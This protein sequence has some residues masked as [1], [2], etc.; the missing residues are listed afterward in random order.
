MIIENPYSQTNPEN[1]SEP[2]DNSINVYKSSVNPQGGKN[3]L[4]LIISVVIILIAAI[5]LVLYFTGSL[6]HLISYS[7]ASKT[8]FPSYVLSPKYF[9][10]TLELFVL[11]LEPAI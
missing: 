10:F 9:I 4:G 8:L 5:L 11:T 1:P 7:T 6:S 2:S 3:K